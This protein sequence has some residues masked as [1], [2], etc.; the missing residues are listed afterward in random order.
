MLENFTDK[1]QVP[2]TFPV[3]LQRILADSEQRGLAWNSNA[4]VLVVV[5]QQALFSEVIPQYISTRSKYS[6]KNFKDQLW[7]CGF[8]VVTIAWRDS[9]KLWDPSVPDT[10]AGSYLKTLYGHD[11]MLFKNDEV[12]SVDSFSQIANK[13]K[14]KPK[15]PKAPITAD[16]N[17]APN[18][19]QK[20]VEEAP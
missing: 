7:A 16:E 12:T 15:S 11:A 8:N 1:L 20:V 6:L 17:L 19:K 9:L 3:K 10:N 4:R 5:D 14:K 18:K 2:D 13:D